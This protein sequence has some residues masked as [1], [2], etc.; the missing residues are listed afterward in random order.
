MLTRGLV[1]WGKGLVAGLQDAQI[2][3]EEAA[4]IRREISVYTEIYFR[5][6]ENS[7]PY[8]RASVPISSA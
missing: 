3:G 7:A 6:C 5:I 8:I 4:Y 2:E 1:Y